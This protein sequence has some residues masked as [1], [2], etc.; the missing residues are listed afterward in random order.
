MLEKLEEKISVLFESR[1]NGRVY[2]DEFDVENP[3]DCTAPKDTLFYER[4][5]LPAGI[6]LTY[7]QVHPMS[8]EKKMLEDL[9]TL[10]SG[11]KTKDLIPETNAVCADCASVVFPDL[12]EASPDQIC[13]I[14]KQV[15]KEQQKNKFLRPYL[16]K[17][18]KNIK[19]PHRSESE[20]SVNDD[21]V[22][23]IKAASD[24]VSDVKEI[25]S[26]KGFNPFSSDEE[27]EVEIESSRD[28]ACKVC[29]KSF[30]M[31][32][33]LAYHNRIFHG[34]K[35]SSNT[36]K[37]TSRFVPEAEQLITTFVADENSPVKKRKVSKSTKFTVVENVHK[38][39]LREKTRR[40]LKFGD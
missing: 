20:E 25:E 7:K 18:L 35:N 32:E 5:F 28:N 21:S 37:V 12:K 1:L 16:L 36:V 14:N 39:N 10:G 27:S 19:S 23:D 11:S 33:F 4:C 15:F 6:F 22:S 34:N 29:C 30:T 31:S 8:N 3:F 24:R 26:K 38:F 17:I 13:E 9:F 40:N 2:E